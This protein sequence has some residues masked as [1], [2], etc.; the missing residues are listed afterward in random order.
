MIILTKK[1]YY[2]THVDYIVSR[3]HAPSDLESEDKEKITK[4]TS[5]P[6]SLFDQ[7]RFKV[8][9]MARQASGGK[10]IRP[11]IEA[12]PGLPERMYPVLM[13]RDDFDEFKE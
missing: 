12:I 4:L 3:S 8:R 13:M 5:N 2:T 9:E 10:S 6:R 1:F 7:A 11:Y